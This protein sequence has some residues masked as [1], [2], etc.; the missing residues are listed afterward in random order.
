MPTK[1]WVHQLITPGIVLGKLL[2]N[3]RL[4]TGIS[5]VELSDR[6]GISQA[7]LSQIESG[8][9]PGDSVLL[10]II[11][12]LNIDPADLPQFSLWGEA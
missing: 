4:Y 8:R 11:N 10:M 9:I 5:Q 12:E 7:Y 6:C 2:K 3:A 1:S